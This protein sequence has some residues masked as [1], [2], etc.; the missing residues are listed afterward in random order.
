LKVKLAR[1]AGFCM[2]VRRAM[3]LALTEANS[4]KRPL[5][6][7]GPLIHN[8]QVLD[9]LSSKGVTPVNDLKDLTTGTIIIRA[10]GIPPQTR[11]AIKKSNLDIVDATC[12]RV[13]HVQAIIRYHTQKGATA[14]IVGNKNHAEVIG[15]VGY[16]KTPAHVIQSV[17]DVSALPELDQVFVVSQT[18]QNELNYRKVVDALRKR[19]PDIQVFH[20][21][22]EATSHRQQEVRGFAG[23][24]DAVVVVGGFHSGN[25]LR[26]AQVSEE[27]GL[28]TFHVETA[29]DLDR[30]KLSGMKVV[31]VTAG[32]S[33]PNWMIK[34]VVSEIEGIKGKKEPALTHWTKKSLKLLLANNAIAAAG[35][36]FLAYAA[37]VLSQRPMDFVFPF[38]A[39]LYVYAMHVLNR[40]LDRGA[41]AYNDPERAAFLQKHRSFLIV[42]GIGAIISGLALSCFVG[43]S[44]FLALCAFNVLGIAYSLPLVP[45]RIRN[46]HAYYK[47]KDIPGSRSLSEAL[48]WVA[49]IV[50]LPL[51]ESF[52]GSPQ[53]AIISAITVFSMSYTRAILFDF[54]Q[55]QGDVIVGTETLPITLGE[56]KTLI[57]IRFLIFLT[58]CLL[59]SSPLLGLTSSFAFLMLL[60]LMSL[61]L[62]ILAY[63]K[64]WLYPG[65][66]LELLTEGNFFLAGFL[67]IIWRYLG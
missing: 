47:I 51:L 38:L 67:A 37:A 62:C 20:T 19:Y 64:N 2:G 54:F 55:A 4:G 18:T 11:Q 43:T 39:F 12:P 45:E 49:V 5:F 25:T 3:A 63:A 34:N 33:T 10:H 35:A 9:L 53:A 56:R 6:T 16:S 13:A 48:A 29:R 41:S 61:S 66:R 44:T 27:A 15:L 36:F 58:A 17:E 40:F 14:I 28:T 21:I 24:V 57:L 46:R 22:C 59:V 7:F 52:S 32:A 60:P 1:T 31:G 50:I 8:K 23:L 30:E 26:L 42:T 65:P